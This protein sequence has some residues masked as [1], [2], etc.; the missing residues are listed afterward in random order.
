MRRHEEQY[1]SDIDDA[2]MM[3]PLLLLWL[4]VAG[5]TSTALWLETLD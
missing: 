2:D 1:R 3:S 4:D 5:V